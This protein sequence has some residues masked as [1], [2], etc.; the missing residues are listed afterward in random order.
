[1]AEKRPRLMTP[2]FALITLSALGYFTSFGALVPVL[3][4]YAE[5]GLGAG[6][7][8]VGMAVGAFSF[9]AFFLRPYV[10]R[11]GDRRGR[12]VLMVYG[13]AIV[14][15]SVLALI[16]ADSLFLVILFRLVMGVGEAMF[17]VGAMSAA[18]DVAPEERRGEAVSL[19]TLAL[20]IGLALGPVLGETVLGDGRFDAAWLVSAGLAFLAVLLALRLPDTRPEEVR[21]HPPAGGVRFFHP[22]ALMPGV[23]LFTSVAGF[24][25]F[26]AFLALYARDL[27][28]SNS[29][30]VFFAYASIIVLIRSVGRRLPDVLGFER[31]IKLALLTSS[32]GLVVIALWQAIPGLFVGTVVFAVGQGLAFPSIMAMAVRQTPPS[33]R[34]AAVGTVS[35]F[36]DLS[37]GI[38]PIALGAVKSGF[39][40]DGMFL[41]AG[42]IA[43]CGFLLTLALQR[44]RVEVRAPLVAP[45]E[46]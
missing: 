12:R 6:P 3:P 26:N 32:A 9:S 25:G 20:Y 10:G 38:G 18:N 1:M 28:I 41:F 39:G 23:L 4:V 15:A 27:G 22:A 46:G 14:M 17:F 13:A 24:A 21:A 42:A 19:F 36:F 30:L 43:F 2:L 16:P 7:V 37:F 40:T 29:G 5:D 45:S 33:E 44:R 31:A 34:G 11:I 35:A 8:G